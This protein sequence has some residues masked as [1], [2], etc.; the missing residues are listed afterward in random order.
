MSKTLNGSPDLSEF[1]KEA[2]GSPEQLAAVLDLGIEMLFYLEE[3][4]F[5]RKDVQHVASAMRLVR[6]VLRQ[7]N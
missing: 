3:D 2:Y 1:I 5:E 7:G 4:T 6:D